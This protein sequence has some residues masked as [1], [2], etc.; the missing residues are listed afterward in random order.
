MKENRLVRIALFLLLVAF[1]LIYALYFMVQEEGV[2]GNFQTIFTHWWLVD[3]GSIPPA[4]LSWH[5]QTT[6]QVDIL[7][8]DD[9]PIQTGN[10]LATVD[11]ETPDSFINAVLATTSGSR[12][13][14][15]TKIYYG[16]LDILRTLSVR[17]EYILKDSQYDIFYVYIG[18]KWWEYK[19]PEIA[20]VVW[21]ETIE[22]YAKNDIINNLYFGDRVS[23][24]TLPNQL[25]TQTNVFV[26]MGDDLWLIQDLT[27]KY[28]L[29]KKHIRYIFTGK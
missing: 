1:S 19:I 28:R 11:N 26:R 3:T 18:K 4:T 9:E 17:Y 15:G 27:G 2:K 14:S 21:G 24:V 29:N 16:T 8:W 7:S 13:L 23:I 12:V 5:I 25:S 22:I 10:G 6:G 20:S